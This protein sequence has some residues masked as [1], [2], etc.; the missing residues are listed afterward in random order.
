MHRCKVVNKLSGVLVNYYF[1]RLWLFDYV[2]FTARSKVEF[3]LY[4]KDM[5]L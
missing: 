1:V 2:C 3:V 5:T 4:C